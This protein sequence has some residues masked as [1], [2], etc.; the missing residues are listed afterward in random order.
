V[1]DAF[2]PK[3]LAILAW[4][5]AVADE[6]THGDF[7]E[8]CSQCIAHSFTKRGG[9]TGFK[10][11]HLRQIHQFQCWVQLEARQ[12]HP[13][14]L[15]TIYVIYVSQALT[16]LT[17][18]TLLTLVYHTYCTNTPPPPTIGAR[19]ACAAARRDARRVCAC[20]GD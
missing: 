12:P 8:R 17:L 4:C 14:E 10:E 1:I 16:L 2:E 5:Y 6:R 18:Y 20:H 19:A 7:L 13:Y 11:E 9:P 3:S 15:P